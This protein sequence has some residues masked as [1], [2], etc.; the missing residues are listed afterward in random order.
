V[1]KGVVFIVSFV[2]VFRN[3][4]SIGRYMEAS[5]FVYSFTGNW[6]DVSS[7]LVAF[8]RCAKAEPAV[9]KD[10]QHILIRLVSML[11]AVCLTELEETAAST[12]PK[13]FKYEL[14]DPQGIDATTR[15]FLRESKCKVETTF[16]MLQVLL[17]EAEKSGVLAVPPPILSRSFQEMGN[18]MLQFHKAM[19]LARMPLP[20]H[21]HLVSRVVLTIYTL[22][23]PFAYAFWGQGPFTV[24]A[25]VFVMV[26]IIWFMQGMSSVMEHPF[27]CDL[28]IIDMH[29]VHYILNSRLLALLQQ[30]E[31][32]V[33]RVSES[34]ILDIAVLQHSLVAVS[35]TESCKHLGRH[36]LERHGRRAV[37]QPQA[38]LDQHLD[39]LFADIRSPVASEVSQ[40]NP[41]LSSLS[42]EPSAC[43]PASQGRSQ[44]ILHF[45][46]GG[47]PAPDIHLK[48]HERSSLE[49]KPEVGVMQTPA[50]HSQRGADS[51]I[52]MADSEVF[53]V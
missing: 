8:C 30:T 15:S 29:H 41:S 40:D 28:G 33:P 21:Y 44:D 22:Y 4:Y 5:E 13:N 51:G 50:A 2:V 20:F 37:F 31:Q 26:F 43:A 52:P 49:A 48:S 47:M 10:F 45:P 27:G 3:S 42:R 53:G 16:Q 7:S 17:V 34:V 46:P 11:N 6:F 24:F 9:V 18:G 23:T 36:S 14:I 1:Y 39:Q 32:S 12:V 25:F 35:A 19:K 38:A